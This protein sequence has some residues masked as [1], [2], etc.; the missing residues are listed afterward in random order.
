M[1]RLKGEI[2]FT[3]SPQSVFQFLMVRL[4][5]EARPGMRTC[6]KFQFL[7]VR[8]KAISAI[9]AMFFSFI[10]IPYGSIKRG[11]P[12]SAGTDTSR[13]Q[14]LMVRLKEAPERIGGQN[15]LFQFLMVRLKVIS[16]ERSRRMSSI[17]I[18]YGSIKR[19]FI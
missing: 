7:M 3:A 8:L 5:D 9:N 15:S 6:R 4:K 16:P 2:G 11:N 18:P 1:V 17:S 13:F 10:S 12:V 14:F 19:L